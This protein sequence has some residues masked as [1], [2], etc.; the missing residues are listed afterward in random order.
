MMQEQG[1]RDIGRTAEAPAGEIGKSRAESITNPLSRVK[2]RVQNRV[3][4]RIY[5]RMDRHYNTEKSSG[6]PF[7]AASEQRGEK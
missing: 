4:N 3:K 5:N 7:E 2:S 6:D 1:L